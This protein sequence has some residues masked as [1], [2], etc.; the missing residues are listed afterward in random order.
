MHWSLTLTPAARH[1]AGAETARPAPP[2]FTEAAS[3]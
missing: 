2:G 3:L 1:L